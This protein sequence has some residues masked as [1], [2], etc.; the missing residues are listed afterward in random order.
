MQVFTVSKNLLPTLIN[1]RRKNSNF[2]VEKPGRHHLNQVI[3]V[4]ITS[5]ESNRHHVP[6]DRIHWEEHSIPS[7]AFLPTM[8]NLDLIKRE[9]QTDLSWGKSTKCPK[10]FTNVSVMK[11]QDRPKN[12]FRLK[13]T[14]ETWQRNLTHNRVF[15]PP[16]KNIPR[17]TGKLRS[18]DGKHTHVHF[19][20]W[21]SV[22]CCHEKTSLF[23]RH[24]LGHI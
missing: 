3:K 5:S 8:P 17:T 12:C 15:S 14:R 6:P 21:V 24:T 2:T 23:L 9:H 11:Q 18:V 13:E 4:H 22:E 16:I 7:L 10:L 19:L 1:Y 20:I